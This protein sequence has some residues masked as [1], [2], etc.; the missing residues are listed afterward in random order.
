MLRRTEVA[1]LQAKCR[2]PPPSLGSRRSRHA[3]IP[4]NSSWGRTVN[5][6]VWQCARWTGSVVPR[7][8]FRRSTG[9]E[10]VGALH[11]PGSSTDSGRRALRYG[12]T[13]IARITSPDGRRKRHRGV[14]PVVCILP[15]QLT[16]AISGQRSKFP[17]TPPS[18]LV[19]MEQ[20]VSG[21]SGRTGSGSSGGGN[22]GWSLREGLPDLKKDK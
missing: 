21:R 11:R 17:L 18:V 19:R 14:M 15:C 20:A 2:G 9:P 6:N 13:S 4:V 12:C 10:R 3:R 16:T 5:W 1:S 7:Y 22:S 8:H